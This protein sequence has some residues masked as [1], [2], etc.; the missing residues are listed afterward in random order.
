[1]SSPSLSTTMVLPF[2]SPRL[3]RNQLTIR[4][5]IDAVTWESNA[6]LANC[7]RMVI[8]HRQHDDDPETGDHIAIYRQGSRWATWG[9]ARCG[10]VV[11]LWRCATGVDEGEFATTWDALSAIEVVE[12]RLRPTA[13]GQA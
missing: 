11:T 7:C 8:H 5:R 2:A 1:M 6:S 13:V 10:D 12:R 4:D 3:S 9:L